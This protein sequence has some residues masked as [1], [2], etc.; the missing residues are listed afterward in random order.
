VQITKD[1]SVQPFTGYAAWSGTS[2]AAATVSGAIAARTV[3][4]RVTA[5]E[6]LDQLLR[7]PAGG[8]TRY[9]HVD[10]DHDA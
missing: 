10:K 9:V 2:F 4:G 3:P 7:D 5:R 8:I 6:A 1:G